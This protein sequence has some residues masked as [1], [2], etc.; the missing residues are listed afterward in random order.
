MTQGRKAFC[1]ICCRVLFLGVKWEYK[2]EYPINDSRAM[3]KRFE[4]G[5]VR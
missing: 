1:N 4:R 2:N 3:V 5:Y